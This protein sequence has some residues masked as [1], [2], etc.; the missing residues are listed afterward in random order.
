MESMIGRRPS[1]T[2][3]AVG[4]GRLSVDHR[5]RIKAIPMLRA[6]GCDHVVT[7]L[8][9]REDAAAIG[10]AVQAAG[11]SWTWLPLPGGHPPEGRQNDAVL[12]GIRV[13]SRELDQG[14]SILVHCSAGMHRTGMIAYALLRWRGHG[15]EESLDLL[16][17]MRRVTREALSAEHLQ[18]GNDIAR[19]HD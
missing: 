18:W 3:I 4:G 15:E 13:L 12:S 16:G 5:P 14:R 8:S 10:R 1:W 7:L 19:R 11:M 9:E 6:S 2:W 17:R